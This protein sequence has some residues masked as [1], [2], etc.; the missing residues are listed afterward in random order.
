MKML[1]TQANQP[2]YRFI[3]NSVLLR[4]S[5]W[6]SVVRLVLLVFILSQPA[7]IPVLWMLGIRILQFVI[8]FE[9]ASPY[10]LLRRTLKGHGKMFLFWAPKYSCVVRIS[11]FLKPSERQKSQPS[12]FPSLDNGN[13]PL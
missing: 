3:C 10:L 8:L 2:S 12:S 6:R 11:T 5:S 7:S 9:G 13:P 4:K 1:P